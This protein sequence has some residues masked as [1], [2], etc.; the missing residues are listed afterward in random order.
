MNAETKIRR[1][2]L[3]TLTKRSGRTFGKLNETAYFAPSVAR[4]Y[5]P[6]RAD[7]EVGNRQNPS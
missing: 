4:S 2:N 5:P 6:L 7:Y 1:N 3:G